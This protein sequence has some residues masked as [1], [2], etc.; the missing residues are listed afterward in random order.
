MK[1]KGIE[2][3]GEK[4]SV[5]TIRLEE[6]LNEIRGGK[7]FYWSILFFDGTGCL[8][9]GKV[10]LSSMEE[11]K[12]SKK[13]ILIAWEDLNFLATQLHQIQDILI[14]GCKSKDTMM[15]YDTDQEIYESC[16]F[17]M[18]VIDG[19]SW[20][21]FS[22]DFSFIDRLA[23]KFKENKFLESDFQDEW[24]KKGLSE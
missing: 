18:E 4:N 22:S 16:D 11:A 7:N 12:N 19:Y 21:I 2:L 5:L 23:L 1:T 20:E 3:L 10:I 8:P 15:R 24:L 13:G 14:V 6:I 17:V 9:E